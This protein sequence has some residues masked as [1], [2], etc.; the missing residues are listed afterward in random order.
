MSGSGNWEFEYY[1]NNRTNSYVRNGTLC[2]RPTLTRDRLGADAVDGTSPTKFEIWGSMPGDLCTSNSFY[3]CSR[4]SGNG[5]IL[6]PIQS[7]R[8][9]TVQSFSFKYGRLEIEAKLPKGDWI[10]PALWLLPTEQVNSAK[11]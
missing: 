8:I 3:G 4:T 10:W 5:N 2:L 7:A 6:N 11:F 1:T 9:R